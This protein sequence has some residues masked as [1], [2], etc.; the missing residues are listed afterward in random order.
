M[1]GVTAHGALFTFVSSAF[2][3][4]ATVT[5]LSVESPSAELADMTGADSLNG[6]IVLVPTGDFARG[7]TGTITIEY[8]SSGIDWQTAVG[9]VGTLTFVSSGHTVIRRAVLETVG[10]EAK[11][12]DVVRGTLKFRMTDYTV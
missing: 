12:G 9:Y 7:A 3:Y 11:A 4:S 10:S 1:A 5:G 2:S 8:L 6:Y